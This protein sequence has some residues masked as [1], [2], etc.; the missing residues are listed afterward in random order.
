MTEMRSH[1]VARSPRLIWNRGFVLAHAVTM[2]LDRSNDYT[3]R[4]TKRIC[5]IGVLDFEYE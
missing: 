2:M 3:L 1:I 4:H 5:P